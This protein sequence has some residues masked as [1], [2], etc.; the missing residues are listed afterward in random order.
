MTSGMVF[1]NNTT[2]ESIN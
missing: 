2:M 1:H